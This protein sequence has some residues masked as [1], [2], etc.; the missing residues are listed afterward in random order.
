MIDG[1]NAMSCPI[2]RYARSNVN[3]VIR[4]RF[5]GGVVPTE[6]HGAMVVG[7]SVVRDKAHRQRLT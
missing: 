7:S 1:G 6:E 3:E 4:F 5:N 2:L